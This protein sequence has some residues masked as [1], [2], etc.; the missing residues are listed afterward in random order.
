[1]KTEWQEQQCQRKKKET[2]KKNDVKR[3]AKRIARG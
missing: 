2:K 1:M 3:V